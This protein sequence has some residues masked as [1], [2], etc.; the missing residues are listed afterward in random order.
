MAV[1]VEAF[2]GRCCEQ[3]HS[4]LGIRGGSSRSASSSSFQQTAAFGTAALCTWPAMAFSQRAAAAAAGNGKGDAGTGKGDTDTGKG[5]KSAGKDSW[6]WPRQQRND[7]R[8]TIMALRGRARGTMGRACGVMALRGR[9]LS[10]RVWLPARALRR[11]LAAHLRFPARTALRLP[12][13]SLR[14]A[15]AARAMA[16]TM[17]MSLS[18]RVR[19]PSTTSS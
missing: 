12:A 2:I 14:A 9:A 3:R 11:A 17:V 6:H 1:V 19:S 4:S 8:G 7:A 13:R 18:H 16:T 15:L 5:N 10:L